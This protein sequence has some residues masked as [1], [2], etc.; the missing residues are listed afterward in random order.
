MYDRKL[1]SNYKY[2]D[3]FPV[4]VYSVEHATTVDDNQRDGIYSKASRFL[5]RNFYIT[6]VRLDHTKE[7]VFAAV[8]TV[9]VVGEFKTPKIGDIVNVRDDKDTNGSIPMVV[10]SQYSGGE[11]PLW[12]SIY[13]DYG[14]ISTIKEH[15]SSFKVA[16]EEQDFIRQYAGTINGYR[17]RSAYTLSKIPKG[18]FALRGDVVFDIDDSVN[19][20]VIIENGGVIAKPTKKQ[21]DYP[22]PLNAPQKFEEN[23]SYQKLTT[24]FTPKKTPITLGVKPGADQ[25]DSKEE[26]NIKV[27]NKNFYSYEPVQDKQFLKDKK[28]NREVISG[29]E[30]T[31]RVGSHLITIN[32]AHA[33]GKNYVITIKGMHDEQFTIVH[34]NG[35]SQIRIRDHKANLIFLEANKTN[36]RI[37]IETK[38][39]QKVELGSDSAGSFIYLRN[40]GVYGTADTSFGNNAGGF[41]GGDQEF[42]LTTT[43]SGDVKNRLSG[44]LKKIVTGT[45]IYLINGSDNYIKFTEAEI[46]IK[47]PQVKI[48]GSV[49]I[50]GNLDIR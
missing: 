17:F 32:D 25:K 37:L 4:R 21:Q 14:Y 47:S 29:E 43:P 39:R 11:I 6:G 27:Y 8:V 38:D 1:G 10:S 18:Q 48:E 28:F 13:N 16:Q 20:D 2:D 40:G 22:N 9:G 42:L 44:N 34:N 26:I 7:M 23:P 24:I 15:F 12:G 36:N 30:Y 45:G 5:T 19:K 50:V 33:N 35:E 31:V 41:R 3:T 46:N 49:T